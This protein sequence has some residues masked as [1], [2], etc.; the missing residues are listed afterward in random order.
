VIVLVPVKV[1]KVDPPF[2]LTFKALAAAVKSPDIFA[3][4]SKL[5]RYA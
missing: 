5:R 2:K 3:E 4:R 1:V